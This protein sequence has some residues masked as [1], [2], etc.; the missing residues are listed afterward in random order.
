MQSH[1]ESQT[2]VQ[3]IGEF[4]LGFF[5][6]KNIQSLSVT[7]DAREK[8]AEIAVS[9]TSNEAMDHI[10]NAFAEHI[11]PTFQDEVTLDLLFVRPDSAVF[12]STED[13]HTNIKSFFCA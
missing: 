2:L 3:S 1:E 13:T 4:S 9:A 11:I 5:S 10:L 12:R 8:S 6:K 7:L